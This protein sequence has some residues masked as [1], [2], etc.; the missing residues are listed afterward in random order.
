MSDLNI[1]YEDEVLLIVDKP[2]GLL[3][4]PSWLDRRETDTLAG[5]AKAYLQKQ[6]DEVKVHTIH[7]LDRPTSGLVVMCKEDGAAKALIEQFQ[8]QTVQKRYWAICRGFAPVQ[9]TLDYPLKEEH[10]RIADKMAATDKAAQEAVTEFRRLGIAELAVPV[11]RYAKMRLS[12]L[13]CKPITG[14][15][16]Q[17]R[18]HLKHLRHPI[19]G[20]TRHGCRHLNRAFEGAFGELSMALR[21]VSMEFVHPVTGLEMSVSVDVDD[22]WGRWFDQ[23]GW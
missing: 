17:I 5:R 20:D 15:K 13:D 11:S 10:D 23:F 12:L 21:A 14:R 7:R 9:Q 22:V 19:L 18:R 3:M 6:G 16:H 1:V 4:H 8:S 2:A